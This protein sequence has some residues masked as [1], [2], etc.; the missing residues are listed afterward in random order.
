MNKSGYNYS[1]PAFMPPEFN[2]VELLKTFQ[3]LRD[4]KERLNSISLAHYGV[5]VGED[6][7]RILNEME[8]LHFQT[9]NSIIKWY[10]ENPTLEYIASKYHEKFIPNSK[11]HT[12]DNLLGLQLQ[13][14]WLIRGLKISGLIS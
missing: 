6:C 5:W 13:L 12:K 9:K 11:N 1:Q 10:N 8:D 3:K 14:K 7:D 4:L 2:E